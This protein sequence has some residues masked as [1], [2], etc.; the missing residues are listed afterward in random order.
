MLQPWAAITDNKLYVGLL[1]ISVFL[2][3]T[4][5]GPG[6]FGNQIHESRWQHIF[7]DFLCHQDPERSYSISDV[8]MAVCSRCL[9]IY[10]SFM[11]GIFV[12]PFIKKLTSTSRKAKLRIVIST[13]GLNALDIIGNA[14]QIWVNTLESRY[15]LGFLF[16]VSIVVLIADEFLKKN[17]N[18]EDTYGTGYAT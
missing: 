7:F 5:L 9:G 13:I 1:S 4:A 8:S 11:I 12:V 18:T 10:T 14:T 3:V 16:G 6:L 17:I 15:I 2:V